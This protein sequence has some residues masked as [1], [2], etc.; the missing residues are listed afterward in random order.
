MWRQTA[1]EA[2]KRYG[3]NF[4]PDDLESQTSWNF[5]EVSKG[6]KEVYSIWDEPG[7]FRHVDVMPGALDVLPRLHSQGHE[8]Y[9]VTATNLTNRSGAVYDKAEWLQEHFPFLHEHNIIICH[10]KFTVEGDVLFDDNSQRNLYQWKKAHQNGLAIALAAGYNH[11]WKIRVRNWWEFEA[12][13]KSS[14]SMDE[15]SLGQLSKMMRQE[16]FTAE[17]VMSI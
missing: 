17:Q 16:L 15:I 11:E 12:I 14:K 13:I 8:I 5:H 1:L 9:V 10:D 6:G 4:N 7:F 2:N 3:D